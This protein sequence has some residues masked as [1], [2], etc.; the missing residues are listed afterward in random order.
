MDGGGERRVDWG[1]SGEGASITDALSV[2]K[3]RCLVVTGISS[4][5]N[6]CRLDL[7]HLPIHDCTVRKRRH[8]LRLH[9]Q[10]ILTLC[11]A[12]RLSSASLFLMG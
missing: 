10:M 4:T 3:R 12:I 2:Y 8:G 5:F 1:G 9:A 11:M 6:L 7:I